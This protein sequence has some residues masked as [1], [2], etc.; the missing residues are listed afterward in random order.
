MSLIPLLLI[1][2]VAVVSYGLIFKL[3]AFLFKHSR[4]KW[5]DSFVFGL[6]VLIVSICAKA[7]VAAALPDAGPPTISVVGLSLC[8]GLGSWFF[9]IRARN[10]AGAQL[11]FGRGFL[12]TGIGFVLLIAVGL[13]ILYAAQVLRHP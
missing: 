12:L 4:L 11:G 13:A 6:L 9:G 8:L 1:S 10:S 3:A 5:A 7:V 2:L